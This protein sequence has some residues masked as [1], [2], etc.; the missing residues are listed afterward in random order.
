M[1][2][3]KLDPVQNL[4]FGWASVAITVDGETV[5]DKQGDIIPTDELEQAAYEFVLKWREADEMH[6][7]I[8]KGHVVESL[9]VTPE[10]LEAL[11]LPAGA[12]QTGWWVGFKVDPETFSKVQSGEFQM[13][14]IEGTAQRVEV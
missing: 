2:I 13:F 10:K 8:T 6:T 12:L 5:I 4:V 1:E 9:V 14:S 11:G 3:K 7:Q